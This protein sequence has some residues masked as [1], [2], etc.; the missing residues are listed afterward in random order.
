M[1]DMET[2]LQQLEA[3]LEKI[4]RQLMGQGQE[5]SAPDQATLR[6]ALAQAAPL[7][8]PPI[9]SSAPTWHVDGSGTGQEREPII[10]NLL[11]WGG[12]TALVFAA[13]Y[14]V[15]LALEQGWLTPT[16][17]VAITALAGLGLV[18]AGILLRHH[19]RHYASYLPAG[20]IV[21]L[22]IATYGAHLYYPLIGATTA[23]G[24]V[25]AICLGSLWLCKL[26]D[27]QIYAFFAV[28]GSYSAPFLFP[29]LRNSTIDLVIY[30]S[31]W[32]AL[33]SIY[34]IL[35]QRRSVLLLAL[36]LALI[37]FDLIWRLNGSQEWIAALLFQT[38][39][40][41]IFAAGT[42]AYSI[43]LKEPMPQQVGYFYLPALLIFYSLQY[44]LLD[45]HLPA[46]APWVAVCSAMAL[47]AA[48]LAARMFLKQPLPAGQMLVTAYA[49]LV[50]FHAGY[51]ESVP[52]PWGPWVALV[53]LPA[54]AAYGL[55][56]RD[57]LRGGWPVYLACTL[58]FVLNYGRMLTNTS[59]AEVPAEAVLHW[60]YPLEL[61][62]AW[63]LAGRQ[64]GTTGLRMVLL[65]AG[66]IGTM[67]AAVD[68]FDDR[69]MVS[70]AWGVLAISC[71]LL[72]LRGR[73]RTLGQ[74]SLLVFA[75]SAGKLLLYDLAGAAPLI[76]IACLVVLGISFYLGGWLYRKM[77]FAE[78]EGA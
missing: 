2:R 54:A 69:L 60:L 47:A 35:V 17:Q 58:I 38:V 27:S 5:P 57:G 13:S 19:D 12:A 11:G 18:V 21:I 26:F 29:P 4:E 34:A 7:Q 72:A 46:W 50:L 55:W 20:G 62:L 48:Y 9:A 64:Q 51:L 42:A 68:A 23:I 31:A 70:L 77:E 15:R 45:Q 59:V 74:S 75:A 6:A 43:R 52:A 10:G 33:F 53:V 41:A 66:H 76:R 71:L 37:G 25:I 30:F 14:L 22:F 24:A 36:Y 78:G 8:E 56:Q 3:R 1:G 49:A 63:Y 44:A 40:L 73:E 16:R 39:Q 67:A 65:Y 28:V 61:Y 32:S